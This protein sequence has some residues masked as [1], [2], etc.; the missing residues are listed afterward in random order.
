MTEAL[1]PIVFKRVSKPPVCD[2]NW[3]YEGV[4]C[5]GE[6]KINPKEPVVK[7]DKKPKATAIRKGSFSAFE[8][9]YVPLWVHEELEEAI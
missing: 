2:C 8:R 6:C 7:P 9:G 4:I 1:R 3:L 5:N